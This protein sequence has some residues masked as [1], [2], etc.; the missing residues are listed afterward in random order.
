[1]FLALHIVFASLGMGLPLLML[2]A[3]GLYLRSGDRVWLALARRWSKAF[4]VLFAVGAVSGTIISFELGLLWPR[5]M[6]YWLRGRRTGRRPEDPFTLRAIAASGP[7]AFPAVELGWMVT[8][9]G[10]QPWTV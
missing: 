5:F 2:V 8:E 4:G 3:E 10:R 6:D 9:L 1:V 7:L